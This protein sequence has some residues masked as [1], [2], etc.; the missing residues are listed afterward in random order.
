VTVGA[1]EQAHWHHIRS[2]ESVLAE[3]SHG[4]VVHTVGQKRDAEEFFL[5]RE[6]DRILEEF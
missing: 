5:L 6:L 2:G 3:K 1:Y 4:S